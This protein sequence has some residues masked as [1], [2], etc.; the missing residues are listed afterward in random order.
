[1]AKADIHAPYRHTIL[2]AVERTFHTL[3]CRTVDSGD[4]LVEDIAIAHDGE[5]IPSVEEPAV[6]DAIGPLKGDIE[7]VALL[8]FQV[9]TSDEHI[10]HIAHVEVHIHLLKR[11]G[12]EAAGIVGTE[13]Y[14]RQF[15]DHGE[16]FGKSLLCRSR[17]IIVSDTAH[18]IQLRRDVPVE[19]CIAVDIVLCMARVVDELVCREIVVHVVGSKDKAVVT[20]RMAEQRMNDMLLIA[21]IMVMGT[22]AVGQEVGLV[23]LVEGV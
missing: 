19:L 9:R 6:S 22:C 2:V 12:P 10:P 16:S 13:G 1:M 11:R 14:P 4:A 8:R 20:K 5:V 7:I 17:E 18:D 3:V 21:V 23:V 15:V